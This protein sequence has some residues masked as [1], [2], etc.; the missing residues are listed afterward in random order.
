MT[1]HKIFKVFYFLTRALRCKMPSKLV[2]PIF[3]WRPCWQK[4]ANTSSK[5]LPKR[6]EHGQKFN[7]KSEAGLGASEQSGWILGFTRPLSMNS[8]DSEKK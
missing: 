5:T 8:L 4:L 1:K 7:F 3:G 6:N 2:I